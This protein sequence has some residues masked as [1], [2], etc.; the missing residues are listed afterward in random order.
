MGGRPPVGSALDGARL[1]AIGQDYGP[2]AALNSGRAR[3]PRTV[4]LWTSLCRL[5][6]PA[7]LAAAKRPPLGETPLLM[8]PIKKE[9][10]VA[11]DGTAPTRRCWFLTQRWRHQKSA[12]G[13]AGP[14]RPE[15][16]DHCVLNQWEGDLPLVYCAL[17]RDLHLWPPR[18]RPARRVTRLPTWRACTFPFPLPA[19][20]VRPV[21]LARVTTAKVLKLRTFAFRV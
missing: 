8:V 5:D 13:T 7:S 14:H 10:S 4:V 9:T 20:G 15:V 17:R 2:L 6:N 12:T 19:P 18:S 1:N 21:R 11:A 16:V 3:P